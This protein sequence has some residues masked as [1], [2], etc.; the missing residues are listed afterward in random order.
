MCA[1]GIVPASPPPQLLNLLN[2]GE[3]VDILP[4]FSAFDRVFPPEGELPLDARGD[5][6]KKLTQVRPL[7]LLPSLQLTHSHSSPTTELAH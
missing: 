7:L 3:V 6:P 5:G 1:C 4:S 2:G